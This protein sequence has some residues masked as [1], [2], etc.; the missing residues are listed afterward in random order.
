[1]N[2][3]NNKHICNKFNI[4]NISLQ[5]FL[6]IYM[7]FRLLPTL[8]L[9][10]N[11]KL[12]P[13]FSVIKKHFKQLYFSADIPLCIQTHLFYCQH[14]LFTIQSIPVAK[15]RFFR[16]MFSLRIRSQSEKWV[17]N[18]VSCWHWDID[19]FHAHFTDLLLHDLFWVRFFFCIVYLSF[20]WPFFSMLVLSGFIC[21]ILNW[22]MLAWMELHLPVT[23]ALMPNLQ[24]YIGLNE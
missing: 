5:V 22:Q 17:V 4:L 3:R 15:Y 23:C 7:F 18:S 2:I 16:P 24:S 8:G 1:M 10:V 19:S 9:N 11:M 6:F 20:V 14:S 12:L 13:D 21:A